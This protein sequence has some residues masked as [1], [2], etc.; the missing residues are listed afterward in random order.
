MGVSISDLNNY[1]CQKYNYDDIERLLEKKYKNLQYPKC[2]GFLSS[3]YGVSWL[4]SPVGRKW[5]LTENGQKLINDTRTYWGIP[6][7]IDVIISSFLDD[8]IGKEWI[9][10]LP[11][12]KWVLTTNGEKWMNKYSHMHKLSAHEIWLGTETGRVWLKSY[13]GWK[14]IMHTRWIFCEKGKIW[15]HSDMGQ[16]WLCNETWGWSYLVSK[17][18]ADV[19]SLDHINEGVC[20]LDS[21]NGRKWINSVESGY[22]WLDTGGKE[23]I[24]EGAGQYWLSTTDGWRWM[25]NRVYNVGYIIV[26]NTWWLQTENGFLWLNSEKYGGIWLKSS[27]GKAWE[28]SDHCIQFASSR[29]YGWRWL[30]TPSGKKWVGTKEGFKFLISEEGVEYISENSE[31]LNTKDGIRYMDY[32][33]KCSHEDR[34][35]LQSGFAR[36]VYEKGYEDKFFIREPRMTYQIGNTTS[37]VGQVVSIQQ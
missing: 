31:F 30:G 10:T 34:E 17:S 16:M 12:Q 3:C 11:G 5:L 32:V 20:W 36:R 27:G 15:L 23:W 22:Q 24:Y 35:F 21:S 29:E 9:Q 6:K 2:D 8:E 28:K 26:D 19:K 33:K 18:L 4:P 25:G 7:K 37:V 14:W 1:T 13:N